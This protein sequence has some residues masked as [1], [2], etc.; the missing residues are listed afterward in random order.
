MSEARSEEPRSTLDRLLGVYPLVLAYILLLIL[1]AWQAS[2]HSTPWLF[3]DELEWAGRSRGVAH[4]GVPQLRLHDVSFGSL[5]EY[6]IAP[7]W[8]LGATG[9]AYAAAKYINAAVMT[10]SIFPAY[11]L[12]RLFVSRPAAFACGVATAVIPALVYSG[13]L[14]PEPL[15]YFWSTLALWLLARALL[16]RS[17]AAVALAVAVIVVAPAV[18][19]ELEVLVIG[20][21]LAAVLDGRDERGGQSAHEQLDVEGADRSRCAR[22]RCADRSG[23]VCQLNTPTRGTS[24][25]TSTT[26]CSR[27]AS[28]PPVR[29]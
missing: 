20:G 16:V 17:R 3:T 7:A 11:A 21:L 5:Y 28:G 13:M 14:I 18:R 27:T 24:A 26:D 15:A 23:G 8:W 29:S 4:H 9:H 12:A 22:H 1:Y 25:P 10:A 2:K 6:L 19:S